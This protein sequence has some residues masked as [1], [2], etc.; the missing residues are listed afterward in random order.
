M[1]EYLKPVDRESARRYLDEHRDSAKIVAGG[2]SLS[3]LLRQGLLD[4]DVMIDISDVD[5]FSGIE[6]GPDRVSIGAVTTYEQLESHPVSSTVETLGDSVDV[7]ADRQVRTAGTIGGAISHADPSLDIVPPLLCLDATVRIGSV[8]GERTVPLEEFHDGYMA[9][10]L[11]QNELVEG[12]TF[13]GSA[14][15][16]ESNYAKHSRVSGGWATVGIASR[17]R[18]TDDRDAFTDVRI[19][20]AAV[21]DTAVRLSSVEDA[22]IGEP[23]DRETVADAASNATADIDPLDDLSGS[24]EYKKHLART[25]VERSI[26]RTVDRTGGVR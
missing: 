17:V 10:D 6:T 3:L 25:L 14:S 21:G 15:D 20:A 2:Q 13:D 24:A 9:A 7:I 4:P 11:A 5:E 8:D 1:T 18:T 19:A 26:N 23:T 22:L 16:W 12:I